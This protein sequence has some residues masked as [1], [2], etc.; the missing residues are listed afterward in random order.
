M[1]EWARTVF[2]DP[3]ALT[4]RVT[5][6]LVPTQE[7]TDD[8]EQALYLDWQT[9]D[10]EVGY[11]LVEQHKAAL[12]AALSIYGASMM[13][14]RRSL[15][16]TK[17]RLDSLEQINIAEPNPA[18][19][20]SPK[21]IKSLRREYNKLL[22]E[23]QY[24]KRF[25]LS[26]GALDQLLVSSA[27]TGKR[28][29]EDWS[30]KRFRLLGLAGRGHLRVAAYRRRFPNSAYNLPEM[31]AIGSLSGVLVAQAAIS[32]SG[33]T[34]DIVIEPDVAQYLAHCLETIALLAAEVDNSLQSTRLAFSETE[35]PSVMLLLRAI[36]ELFHFCSFELPHAS[37]HLLLDP[38]AQGKLLVYRADN[39]QWQTVDEQPG[40]RLR[41]EAA[42]A[43]RLLCQH[44]PVLD[45]QQLEDIDR[46]LKRAKDLPRANAARYFEAYVTAGL[47]QFEA[48]DL[49]ANNK[50]HVA[51]GFIERL[52]ERVLAETPA[53]RRRFNSEVGGP[54]QTLTAMAMLDKRVFKTDEARFFP[55]R[56]RQ[57][58][59]AR[60]WKT[61]GKRRP[62]SLLG[63]QYAKE[64]N[65]ILELLGEPPAERSSLLSIQLTTLLTRTGGRLLADA[66]AEASDDLLAGL[67]FTDQIRIIG[68]LNVTWEFAEKFLTP[69]NGVIDPQ[70]FDTIFNSVGT[71]VAANQGQI[72][73]CFGR[74]WLQAQTAIWRL[75][76]TAAPHAWQFW[77]LLVEKPG[78]AEF[79]QEQ[80]P[81]Q[82]FSLL[83]RA[84]GDVARLKLLFEVCSPRAGEQL[85]VESEAASRLLLGA[86]SRALMIGGLVSDSMAET[87]SYY[88]DQ[89]IL[90]DG[91]L[92]FAGSFINYLRTMETD[93]EMVDDNRPLHS[94]L[95]SVIDAL[96]LHF[97]GLKAGAEA[98][99]APAPAL[100]LSDAATLEMNNESELIIMKDG[101]SI[102]LQRAEWIELIRQIRIGAFAEIEKSGV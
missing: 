18:L 80:P 62:A 65:T 45:C 31:V 48:T 57:Q 26:M 69:L 79:A 85:Q 39:Q 24:L 59:L 76:R 23:Q 91:G 96:Q 28:W 13:E 42:Q 72:A 78:W 70:D 36:A 68:L 3:L 71:Q 47:A 92:A 19:R 29:T 38:D 30:E 95:V 81:E 86:L 98:E 50:F 21:V 35:W 56:D 52:F 7:L 88:Y 54:R 53:L 90:H 89:S 55:D 46:L 99:P 11:Q 33:T 20:Y 41:R 27:P 64:I 5:G 6:R 73:L 82:S 15:A 9:R 16:L 44:P 100:R 93:L 1:L 43:A 97:P 25:M 8:D 49:S 74:K 58:W 101:N 32:P 94:L 77:R 22:R 87:F 67:S 17:V 83:M 66:G 102:R 4:G 60:F 51:H 12:A 34:T 84:C 14:R 63:K 75:F 10:T 61:M 40:T 2:G 37:S